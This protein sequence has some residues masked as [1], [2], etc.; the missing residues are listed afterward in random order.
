MGLKDRIARLEGEG[1]ELCEERPPCRGLVY[2][3]MVRFPDGT[4]VRLGD[5]PPPLCETCPYREG[6]EGGAP[7]PPIRHI[8]VW[9]TYS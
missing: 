1:P 7:R 5:P 4:H 3:E 2:T 6:R 8:E 9:R